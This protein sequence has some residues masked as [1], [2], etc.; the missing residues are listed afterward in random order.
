[1]RTLRLY[2]VG[3][4]VL[5][6]LGGLSVAVVAQDEQEPDSR[7]P[8]E[9]SGTLR[10]V[11]EFQGS[12]LTVEEGRKLVRGGGNR[13]TIEMDD[14]RLSG[15]LW[16]VL[17]R[18]F[19]GDRQY[20]GDGAVGT[21]AVELVNEDGSWVGTMRGYVSMDPRTHHWH[22]ELTGTGAHDGFSALLYARRPE[23]GVWDVEGFVFPG[24]LPA[25]PDPVVVPAE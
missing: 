16:T 3:T 18:D 17:N 20:G 5:G 12:T 9:V 25:Y 15:D 6:L 14:P 1:M 13:E 23:T 10:L 8:H 21:G 22:Y 24:A 4:V 11:N 2:I 7:G 19:I